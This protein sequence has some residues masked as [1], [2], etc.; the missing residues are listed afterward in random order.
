MRT[1]L[2]FWGKNAQEEK[3][4]LGIKLNEKEN[5]VDVY[6][7]PESIATE[8]FVNQMH[9]KWRLGEDL[10]F[11]EGHTT[12]RVDATGCAPSPKCAVRE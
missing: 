4:L 10:S 1:R 8:D 9:Q 7:F 11:P 3:V 12:D 2:V 6:I 5:D